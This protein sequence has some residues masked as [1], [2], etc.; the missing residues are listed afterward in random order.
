M[1]RGI[2]TGP[3]GNDDDYRLR[4]DN[5]MAEVKEIRSKFDSKPEP[6]PPRSTAKTPANGL[7][8]VNSKDSGD[9]NPC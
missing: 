2:D 4:I 8:K 6:P 3:G 9:G 7:S 1:R 5:W